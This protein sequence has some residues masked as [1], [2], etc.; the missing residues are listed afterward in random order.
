MSA[1]SAIL[2]AAGESR[3]MGGLNK[4]G[5]PVAGV[6]LLRH[7]VSTL[8]NSELGELVVVVG[9]EQ[10]TARA[11]V[12]DLPVRLVAN[13]RYREGQ[14][15]SVYR[16]MQA[17]REP[18]D[19][20]MVCLCD[21]PLLN[22]EDINRLIHA[23]VHQCPTSVLVPTWQ[24]QRG[25]PVILAY[26]H[27]EAILA[28]GRNLGCRRLIDNNPELVTPLAMDNDHVA[29]DLDTPADYQR[30]SQRLECQAAGAGENRTA[31]G[32]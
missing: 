9:H 5:L 26:A 32:H 27:R 29:F 10:Q 17:L 15:T 2:L 16:G 28:G 11:L 8:L 22:A 14:M 19:G 25:N 6:P 12:A 4:L 23:F 20:V 31:A 18:C 7:T 3:R 1:V 13:E 21:Q 24:G 30:L